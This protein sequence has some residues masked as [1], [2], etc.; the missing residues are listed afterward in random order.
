MPAPPP[1]PIPGRL[2]SSKGG[3]FES[4]SFEERRREQGGG[5]FTWSAVGR[6]L[7]AFMP[8]VC[9]SLTSSFLLFRPLEGGRLMAYMRETVID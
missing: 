8:I 2:I 9:L 7:S 3:T 1:V 4:K 6:V 5:S